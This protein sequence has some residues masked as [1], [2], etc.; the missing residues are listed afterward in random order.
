[1]PIQHFHGPPTTQLQ[2]AVAWVLANLN[3]PGVICPCCHQVAARRYR[4]LHHSMAAALILLARFFRANTDVRWVH[5][6]QYFKQHPDIPS[7]LRGD[8]PK[9]THWGLLQMRETDAGDER[10]HSGEYRVTRDGFLFVDMRLR[11]HKSGW[12]FNKSMLIDTN[13]P[14][15]NIRDALGTRFNYDELMGQ[16]PL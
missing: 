2:E 7:A 5:A 4:H 6:E 13:S 14:L 16:R 11:V 9:L 8:F 1:M 12:A 3:S 15:I 10:P